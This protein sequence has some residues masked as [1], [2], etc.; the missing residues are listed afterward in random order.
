MKAISASIVI[1]CATVLLIAG[2]YHHHGDTGLFLS[3]VGCI[4]GIIGL[5]RLLYD[6]NPADSPGASRKES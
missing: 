4:I 2:A 6:G 1:V 3:A 5:V